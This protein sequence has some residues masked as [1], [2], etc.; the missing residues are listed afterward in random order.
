MEHSHFTLQ[1]DKSSF[2]F[3]SYD[4]IINHCNQNLYNDSTFQLKN[5]QAS[6]RTR[7]Q[8]FWKD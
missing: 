3:G 8:S 1:T 6:L 5:L 7:F 2:P 4:V